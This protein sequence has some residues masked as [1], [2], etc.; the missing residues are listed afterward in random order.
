[1]SLE[2]RR[3]QV[4]EAVDP[5]MEA[6]RLAAGTL[7]KWFGLA[8]T[9]L[10]AIGDYEA[11]PPDTIPALTAAGWFSTGFGYWCHYGATWPDVFQEWAIVLADAIWGNLK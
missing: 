1:M 3:R 6:T 4:R 8:F 5:E 9:L 2:E 7:F 11:A 10:L